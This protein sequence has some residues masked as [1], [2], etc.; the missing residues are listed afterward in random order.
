PTEESSTPPWSLTPEEVRVLGCLLEKAATTPE[1]YPLSMNSLVAACCQKTNRDPVVDYNEALVEEAIAGLRSNGLALLVSVAGSRVAK[2]QHALPRVYPDLNEPGT[3][4]L[5]V[6][7][8]RGRQTLGE[9]R[10]RTERIFA[11]DSL[12]AVQAALDELVCF[13]PRQL[14]QELPSGDG[15]RV[16][17]FIHLLGDPSAH[18]ST[19]QHPADQ[20][21]TVPAAD[22]RSDMEQ[23][24]ADLRTEVADLRRELDE[25]RNQFG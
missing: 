14:V 12:D 18:P 17:T 11:F 21:P 2:F 13:P 20:T 5:T 1:Q 8:L 19:P 24:I 6:L 4:L 9:L 15:H 10:T 23:T 3:A 16:P 25:F 7:L 22:W